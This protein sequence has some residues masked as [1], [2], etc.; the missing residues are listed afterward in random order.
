MD[1][2]QA[3]DAKNYD[4]KMSNDEI[5]RMIDKRNAGETDVL[6]SA[7]EGVVED[8]DDTLKG[9]GLSSD[10]NGPRELGS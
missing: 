3:D 4:G 8:L 10:D 1:D 5:I 7:P 6:S 2:N 9:V